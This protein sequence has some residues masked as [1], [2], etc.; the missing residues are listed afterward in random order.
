ME[1]CFIKFMN[2]FISIVLSLV[3]ILFPCTIFPT[4]NPFSQNIRV[5]KLNTNP[6]L[7]HNIKDFLLP[8]KTELFSEYEKRIS[9]SMNQFSLQERHCYFHNRADCLSYRSIDSK[10]PKSQYNESDL[11]MNFC[12]HVQNTINPSLERNPQIVIGI[13]TAEN[14][15]VERNVLR[16]TWCN[17]R[18]AEIQCIFTMGK[19]SSS[20]D[21]SSLVYQES[22]KYQDILLTNIIDSYLNLTIIQLQAFQW[23]LQNCKGMKYYIRADS[24][25]Y[26][27]MTRIKTLLHSSSNAIQAYGYAFRKA[28]PF[29]NP[30]HKYYIPYAV[31]SDMYWPTYLSGCM[32]IFSKSVLRKIVKGAEMIRPIHYLDDAYYG[33]IL[34]YYNVDITDEKNLISVNQLPLRDVV[35]G[36]YIAVHRF[37]PIDIL[38]VDLIL[39]KQ[40]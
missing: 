4:P 31:Y 14:Q 12:Y 5:R 25:M 37:T 36:N 16:K 1:I 8:N 30:T 9:A 19:S 23:V 20:G 38:T 13:V 15:F 18:D 21:W 6:L 27:N 24:D 33:Q 7:Y 39:N 34:N 11:F 40:W 35:K 29:R 26:I 32:C 2:S 3:I 17:P 10:V 28:K 22:F